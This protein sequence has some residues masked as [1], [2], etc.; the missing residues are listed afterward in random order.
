M[1]TVAVSDCASS[2]ADDAICRESVE[3]DQAT[4]IIEDVLIGAAI[5]AFALEERIPR[6]TLARVVQALLEARSRGRVD[7]LIRAAHEEASRL[8]DWECVVCLESNPGTFELCWN[9][10]N[11]SHNKITRLSPDADVLLTLDAS[12]LLKTQRDGCE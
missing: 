9:C 4:R 12:T 5:A 7:K 11:L 1:A 10:G 3:S 8:P 6:D 2:L